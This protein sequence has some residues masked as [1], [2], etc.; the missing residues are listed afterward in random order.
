MNILI[1]EDDAITL[2]RI[3]HFLEKWDHHVITAKDGLEALEKF[4][5]EEV[6][7]VLTDWNMPQMDGLELVRR[8]NKHT[9]EKPYVY[10]I[11]LTSRGDKQD[12]VA[13]LSEEGVDDY[14]VKPFDPDELKARVGV[15]QRTVRLERALKEYGQGL[16]K[17]VRKQTR[18]IRETQ[19]ETIYRL[20]TALETRDE[21]TGGHVRRI[22][23]SSAI[24]AEALG[25]ER[26]KIEDMR[27]AAPMHDI[28]KIGVPDAIL[29]KPGK[30]TPEEF[31]V[32]KTHTA[33]GGQILGGSHFRMLQMA[34]DI[35]V[36]HHEK[37]NGTGYPK[38]LAGE[39]IPLAGRILAIV[40][41]FDAL[42]HD[43]VYH[44]AEPEKK[45]LEIMRQGRGS[46]FDPKLFDLFIELLPR[47]RVI[48]A[49]NP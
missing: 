7:I 18:V 35:A 21:E 19:E 1:A 3:Q 10:T 38:T 13:A 30:L 9:P 27:L 2:R 44:K 4:I 12:V 49:E 29:L 28:G 11:F 42:S 40:D 16:E 5:S 48:A 8:I 23:L 34:H 37:W 25:W 39:A 43:R 33:I 15:G 20:L 31:E 6:D 32:M 41:V 17:I 47:L 46:H 26:D 22:A 36:S 45:V 24:M 14:L